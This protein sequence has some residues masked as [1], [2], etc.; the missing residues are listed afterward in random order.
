MP[1]MGLALLDRDLTK[2]LPAA[3]FSL[4]SGRAADLVAAGELVPWRGVIAVEGVETGDRRVIDLGALRWDDLPLPLMAQFI[5]PVGGGGHDGAVLAGRI[6][7]IV[8]IDK[9]RIE[10]YGYI[11]PKAPGG[12]DLINAL[13]NNLMRGIS[14]D[15]DDVLVVQRR[16]K[17]GAGRGIAS[18]RIRGATATPFQAIVQATIA[19][20]LDSLVA[21]GA[22][23]QTGNLAR[24]TFPID[25]IESYLQTVEALAAS[26]GIPV[27]P[28][29]AWFDKRTFT[30]I[31]PLTI[32]ADGQVFGHIATF[33][34]CHI[35][36]R[37]CEPVPRSHSN[38]ASFRT[39]AVLT[40]EGVEVRTGPLMMDTVH[41]DLRLRASDAQAFY[42]HTG[43]GVADVIPYEDK[44]GIA[45]VGAIRPDVRPEQLR[46]LR[47]SDVSPDWRT[48]DGRPRECV[49]LL[50][51]NNSGFKVPQALAASAG[52]YV[53]PGRTAA[54]VDLNDDVFAL[55]ASGPSIT[56]DEFSVDEETVRFDDERRDAAR[57]KIQLRFGATFR[58]FTCASDAAV[59]T[60]N[61]PGTEQFHASHDQK[62]HGRRFGRP[63]GDTA[64][65][66][67]R[68]VGPAPKSAR[69]R[70]QA[71]EIYRSKQAQN[72]I[73][74]APDEV[75]QY[76]LSNPYQD[77]RGAGMK[78][79]AEA[80]MKRRTRR[81][82]KR[83]ANLGGVRGGRGLA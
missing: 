24:V 51:V 61:A 40:A 60:F 62:S 83:P 38:Y 54:A 35:S 37:R 73:R 9:D 58:T 25:P 76:M 46:A 27:D 53:Q 79:L 8:R 71:E 39:G 81:R 66:T 47:G 69:A 44:F 26:G 56:A 57:A 2:P 65:L 23:E 33:G 31:T 82:F 75:I 59:R 15:L 48:V 77:E 52:A 78:K 3:T 13:D 17:M 19:L 16:G 74:N 45:I 42:A 30:E 49:A 6:D 12:M 64:P 28:P 34:S 21:S 80:E 20:D 70:K 5:N 67:P 7:G 1:G 43:S 11:D 68:R 72:R 4:T 50:A 10:A 32:T 18:G 41:P 36:F 55:V 22:E 63:L 29:L 14:V